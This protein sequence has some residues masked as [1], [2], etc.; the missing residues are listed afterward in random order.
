MEK[1]RRDLSTSQRRQLAEQFADVYC[2]AAY[3]NV[4]LIE[5]A[6]TEEHFDIG[7]DSTRVPDRLAGCNKPCRFLTKF[8]FCEYNRVYGLF[9]WQLTHESDDYLEAYFAPS[10]LLDPENHV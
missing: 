9:P 6:V 2:K 1:A 4:D 7:S 3:R 5:Q 8:A 10:R